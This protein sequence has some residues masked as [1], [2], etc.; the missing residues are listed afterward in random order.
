MKS[1]TLFLSLIACGQGTELEAPAVPQFDN[2]PDTPGEPLAQALE[3][4]SATASA[5]QGPVENIHVNGA[6]TGSGHP[7]AAPI[8]K[9]ASSAQPS[10]MDFGDT[11]DIADED[12][13]AITRVS[14]YVDGDGHKAVVERGHSHVS[15]DIFSTDVHEITHLNMDEF[16]VNLDWEGVSISGWRSPEYGPVF[17]GGAWGDLAAPPVLD[18]GTP[19]PPCGFEIYMS[20]WE[21]SNMESPFKYDQKSG[22]CLNA[23]EEVGL[24]YKPVEFIR[25]TKD[26]E[27]AELSWG[28][29]DEGVP[30]AIELRDWNLAGA[31]L[32]QAALNADE[33]GAVVKLVNASLE[34]A[35]LTGL[36]VTDASITGS[37]DHHTTL[38]DADCITDNGLVDCEG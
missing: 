23:N 2:T 36:D 26:G 35:D 4:L 30:Y 5:Q 14:V 10:W 8:L 32:D 20:C 37:I 12:R 19:P 33:Q 25:E 28:M 38:P 18:S 21:P 6:A 24:N 16:G 9:C 31:K 17:S 15:D 34:G 11:E 13:H 7:E 29:I 22:T 1:A 3:G 27:C